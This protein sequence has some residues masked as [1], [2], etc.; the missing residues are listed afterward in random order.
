MSA[1][2]LRAVGQG[3]RLGAGPRQKKLEYP[4]VSGVPVLRKRLVVDLGRVR[5]IDS[6]GLSGLLRLR[7]LA[8][9]QGVAMCLRDVPENIKALIRLSGIDQVL[10]TE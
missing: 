10:P 7:R 5:F 8:E 9:Q 1:A 6:S 2:E 4:A 3:S